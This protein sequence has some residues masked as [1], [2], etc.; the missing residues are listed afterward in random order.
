[1]ER[2]ISLNEISDGKLYGLNDMV[3]AGC[4][5]CKGCSACCRGMGN[6]IILDPYDISLLTNHLN[7]TFEML[8]ADRIELN[9][10]DGFALPNLKMTG[11]E[12]ACTFLSNEGRCEIHPFR[13]GFC[14]LFP[15]GR[16]YEQDNFHYIL[17][18][19]ECHYPTKT[20][21]KVRNWLDI[22]NIKEYEAYVLDWHFF[23]KDL[24]AV[25]KKNQDHTVLKQLNLYVL[26]LFYMKPYEKA[27]DF[28][29]QF[30][31]RL[32]QARDII[33]SLM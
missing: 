2:H 7:T 20:K 23:L 5:G 28:Y 6:T 11:D 14:R 33:A 3:R 22:P 31:E 9:V 25:M 19:H 29:P 24:Q 10:V 21:V 16:Y 8:M 26:K 32:G 17:Q 30:Y 13:P 27:A 4:N 18:V 12:E 15:L 1:M